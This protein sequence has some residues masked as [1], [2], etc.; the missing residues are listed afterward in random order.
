MVS[1]LAVSCSGEAGAPGSETESGSLRIDSAR[2]RGEPEPSAVVSGEWGI[3]TSTP[4]ICSLLEGKGGE[5]SGWYDPGAQVELDGGRFNRE[6]VRDSGTAPELD[7]ATKYHVR[8]RV[9]V[10]TGK[11]IEATA[12]VRGEVPVS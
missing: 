3:G 5:P 10:D 8:C 11:T 2:W 4:P 1:A 12:P 6:F 7:S 9:S